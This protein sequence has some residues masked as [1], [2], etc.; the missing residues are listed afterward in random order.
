[1]YLAIIGK[2]NIEDGQIGDKDYVGMSADSAISYDL[3]TLKAGEKTLQRADF[4]DKKK[5]GISALFFLPI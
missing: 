5:S 2:N 3:G 4:S 1:M